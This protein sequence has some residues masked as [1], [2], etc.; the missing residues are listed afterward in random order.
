[1]FSVFLF[2]YDQGVMSSLLTLPAFIDYFDDPSRAT[3]AIMVAILELGAFFSSLF[4]GRI[5]DLIGRRKTIRYGAIIFIMGGFIQTFSKKMTDLIFGRVISGLGIGILSMIVPV[6]QSEISPP[7]NRGLLGCV[8]FTGN[9]F[10]YSSSI[11]IDYF[12]SAS[13]VIP[14]NS[15]FSWRFP[16]SIQCI[17]GTLLLLGS[18]VIVET[19]R[20]LL[21]TDH[22]VEGLIVIANL[23]SKGDAAHDIA[24]DEYQTIKRDILSH[25]LT[26][27]KH[28]KGYRYM[29]RKY[30]K[31]VVIGCLCLILAQFQGINLICYYASYVFEQAGWKGRQAVLMT[32]INS[33][34]YVFCTVIP[35][36]VVDKWGRRPILLTGSLIMGV[37]LSL[38]AF[39][40]WLDIPQTPVIVV[41]L[42]IIFTGPGFGTSWGPIAWF[43]PSE[44]LPVSVRSL[45]A[46]CASSANWMANFVVGEMAPILQEKIGWKL[47][48][49]HSSFCLLAF[50]FVTFHLPETAGVS[51][52]EMNSVFN[53]DAVSSIYNDGS[54]YQEISDN[55]STSTSINNFSEYDRLNDQDDEYQGAIYGTAQPTLA[56]LQRSQI[57]TSGELE[58]LSNLARVSNLA[59]S[60][61]STHDIEPPGLDEV[62]KFKQDRAESLKSSIKKGSESIH[63]FIGK[64]L[65][66]S[67]SK[68]KNKALSENGNDLDFSIGNL[69][70]SENDF[71]DD[72][73]LEDDTLSGRID[74]TSGVQ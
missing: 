24:K 56:Q 38:V 33:V 50:Y 32:G 27:G 6:Y 71:G 15:N 9:V 25:R 18:F 63:N 73:D 55:E 52:E 21:S 2:G 42:I 53:D 37:S 51:L 20:W 54:S 19:P 40:L 65:N 64:V 17:I 69:D 34:I 7:K 62:L 39:F 61:I 26:D 36:F 43:I 3:I 46:S 48:L 58:S 5:A 35:W 28:A 14:K 30:R 29:W 47:Y 68:K 4:V 12:S 70:A 41:F 11:W 72:S 23:H 60:N 57:F 10:G 45:G 31:R 49:I 67:N 16:L 1:M 44:I 22:D 8:Q 66:N 59:P 13:S 74:N